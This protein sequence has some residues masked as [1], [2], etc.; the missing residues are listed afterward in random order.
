MKGSGSE[1]NVSFNFGGGSI[2]EVSPCIHVEGSSCMSGFDCMSL[3]RHTFDEGENEF[4]FH[5]HQHYHHDHHRCRR[6][7]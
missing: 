4:L 2:D 5:C 7:H 6:H 1:V 3:I